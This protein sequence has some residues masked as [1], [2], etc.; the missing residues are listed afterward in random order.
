MNVY[1][2]ILTILLFTNV[3]F[4]Q[5]DTTSSQFNSLTL[6]LNLGSKISFGTLSAAGHD[7]TGD[8]RYF[9]NYYAYL[10]L[11]KKNSFLALGPSIGP[12]LEYYDSDIYHIEGKSR[13]NGFHVTYQLYTK[14]KKEWY[15]FFFQYH[16]SYI[17]DNLDGI[18]FYGAFWKPKINYKR[19]IIENVIGCGVNLNIFQNFYI[20]QTLGIGFVYTEVRKISEFNGPY[21]PLG[22]SSPQYSDNSSGYFLPNVSIRLAIGYTFNKK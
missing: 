3:V 9:W 19:T 17:R 5:K 21:G 4:A 11:R 22:P 20:S 15:D 10:T 7:K 6:G 16:M 1:T 2:Y 13:I 18:D 14:S 8:M 12:K